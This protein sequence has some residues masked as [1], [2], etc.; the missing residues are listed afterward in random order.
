MQLKVT[1]RFFVVVFTILSQ[2][3]FSLSSLAGQSD[4]GLQVD[5]TIAEVD[6]TFKP[7]SHVKLY[8]PNLP[9]LAI[10]HAVNGALLRPANNEKGWQYDLA[11]SHRSKDDVIWDFELRQNA[12]FHDGSHFNADS[13]MANVAAFQKDPFTFSN[14]SSVLSHIE[15]TGEYSVRFHMKQPYGAFPYDA[16]WLQFYSSDYLQKFGWNGKQTCPNLVESGLYGIGP[17]IL[18]EGYVEGDRRSSVVEL[19]AN[20]D[21]WGDDKP[22]VERITINLDISPESAFSGVTNDEGVI[23]VMPIAFSNQIETVLS[24]HAKLSTSPSKNNYAMHFNMVSGNEAVK[25]PELRSIINRA[26]DQEYLLNL[27]MLGEGVLSPTMVSPNFYRLDKA[28]ASLDDYLNESSKGKSNNLDSMRAVVA[29]YQKAQ[30]LDANEKLQLTVLAQ[31]SFHFLIKDIAYFLQQVNIELSVEILPTE[32]EVFQQLHVTWNNQNSKHW[33][34][35]LWGNTDWYKHPWSAFF[36]YMPSYA[37]STIPADPLLE[38]Y[39]EKLFK[40]GMESQEYVKVAAD[41]I[42]HVHENN[43]M[44][45]LPTPNNVFAINKEVHFN[46]GSSAFVYLRELQVTQYHWSI[47]GDTPLPEE[48]KQ[49]MQ[50]TKRSFT[51]ND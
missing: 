4:I 13:V 12:F 20:Q 21:Y 39:I 29:N 37:W 45:F 1:A 41:I 9:Y 35:L 50:I 36:V 10:S 34:L 2:A 14:F 22:K 28:I 8:L 16:I 46:P 38:Q 7:G 48:R 17:Y 32:E 31:E 43:L 3:L 47:R 5:N 30:G 11:V 51:K 44:V 33:D 23:D 15:K 49:A 42:R 6:G 40:A 19:V 25:D 27:S 18:S 24:N 26:I